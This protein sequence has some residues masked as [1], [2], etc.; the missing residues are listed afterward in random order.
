MQM[1]GFSLTNTP[2]EFS[3]NQSSSS[4]YFN[5]CSSIVGVPT[6]GLG[7]QYAKTGVGYIGISTY[8]YLFNQIGGRE[9]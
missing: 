2:V 7:F 1:V 5:S 4:D 6:N 3:V 8:N 9:Y